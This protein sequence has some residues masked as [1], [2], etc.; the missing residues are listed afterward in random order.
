M[1]SLPK[2]DLRRL[3]DHAERLVRLADGEI[4]VVRPMLP[5][6]TFSCFAVYQPMFPET[7]RYSPQRLI[8]WAMLAVSAALSSI[9]VFRR[10]FMNLLPRAAT[11]AYVATNAKGK[12]IAL[13][14][15][16]RLR[17]LASEG[18]VAYSGTF[19]AE[20]Y[21]SRGLG[22]YLLMMKKEEGRLFGVQELLATG[23]LQNRKVIGLWKKIGFEPL[24]RIPPNRLLMRLTL[25]NKQSAVS[26][27]CGEM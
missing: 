2:L 15:L 25:N 24:K 26:D 11:L 18:Y 27:F 19:I 17:K 20:D 5:I 4:V 22:T 9:H 14:F 12:I 8:S 6:D 3:K 1:K 7:K 23:Y 13:S 21:Q 16:Y 10:L